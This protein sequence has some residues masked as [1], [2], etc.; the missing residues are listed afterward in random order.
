MFGQHL[1]QRGPNHENLYQLC[2][3]VGTM[4]RSMPPAS[5]PTAQDLERAA[6]GTVAREVNVP[7]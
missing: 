2:V 5:F 4:F 6:V 3:Q 1:A 7:Q